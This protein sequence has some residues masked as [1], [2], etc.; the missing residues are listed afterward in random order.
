MSAAIYAP[1]E[2]IWARVLDRVEVTDSG[3]WLWTGTVNSRGYGC[4]GAGK[5]SRTVLVHRVAVLVRDGDIPDGMT[6]DHTCHHSDVC[7]LANE[8]P[9]R[10]CVN[11]EHL[12]VVTIGDNTRR[13]WESGRCSKGHLLRTKARKGRNARYCPECARPP[14][15][16]GNTSSDYWRARREQREPSPFAPEDVDVRSVLDELFGIA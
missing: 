6:V 4:V 5:R 3:C 14:K 10:R 16:N 8:C 9:H 1:A 2:Q 12:A 15:N 13:R 11:P 7:T